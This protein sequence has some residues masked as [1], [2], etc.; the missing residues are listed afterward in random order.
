[1][2]KGGQGFWE[3]SVIW[4]EFLR[5]GLRLPGQ[6][7]SDDLNQGK[8]MDRALGATGVCLVKEMRWRWVIWKLCI[9]EGSGQIP[10]STR[11]L[12]DGL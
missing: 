8:W 9:T 3:D 5:Q 2:K 11:E 10:C 6:Q 4:A 12:P 7:P 1:M